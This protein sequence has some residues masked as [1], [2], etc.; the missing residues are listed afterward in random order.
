LPWIN[1][2]AMVMADNA[3]MGDATANHF[4]FLGPLEIHLLVCYL[5]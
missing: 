2:V 5:F 1:D 4:D 3:T